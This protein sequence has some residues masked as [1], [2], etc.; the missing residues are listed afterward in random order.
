M[1]RT[2]AARERWYDTLAAVVVVAVAALVFAFVPVAD[3]Y[4]AAASDRLYRPAG[5]GAHDAVAMAPGT[6]PRSDAAGTSG[7]R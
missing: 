1:D 4:G 7:R 3:D 2:R 6:G 5:H